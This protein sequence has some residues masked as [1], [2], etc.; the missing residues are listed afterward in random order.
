M[1]DPSF[2]KRDVHGRIAKRGEADPAVALDI[3]EP[4]PVGNPFTPGLE[5]PLRFW[6]GN[7]VFS[8]NSAPLR[9]GLCNRK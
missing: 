1:K 9:R 7:T 6:A 4:S 2:N 5:F 3:P 8:G